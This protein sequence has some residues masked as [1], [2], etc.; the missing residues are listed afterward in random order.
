M[1]K[2]NKDKVVAAAAKAAAKTAAKQEKKKKEKKTKVVTKEKIRKEVD[3][4]VS[5]KVKK[6][7]GPK[8]AYRVR[9][10]ATLGHISGNNEHGPELK[11]S[12]FLHPSL[13]KGPDDGTEFG[14]L[15]AAAAQYGLWRCSS[16]RVVM[17]P[18]VGPSAVSGTVERLS[19]NLTQTPSS[20]NWGGLGA[21]KHMDAQAGTRHSIRFGRR[22]LAGPRDGGWWMTDTNAEGAQSA[23][24]LIEIHGLGQT[25]SAYQ[26]TPWKNEL[27][28]VELDGVWEFA[29]YTANPS[30]GQLDRK[31]EKADATI[32]TNTAGE[33]EMTLANSPALLRFMDDQTAERATATQPA[34]PGE[35]IFQIVD[36]AASLASQFAP[37]PFG[38]LIKGGWWFLKKI[39]GAAGDNSGEARFLV[40]PSLADAQNNRP[41][42][43]TQHSLAKTSAVTGTFQVTQINAPN[44]GG[45]TANTAATFRQTLPLNPEFPPAS[46]SILTRITAL[47]VFRVLQGAQTPM[48]S[49]PPVF[50]S[51]ALKAHNNTY[52]A[53]HFQAK[54][55]LAAFINSDDQLESFGRLRPHA[56]N[57]TKIASNVI[58]VNY[59]IDVLP[60]ATYSHTVSDGTNPAI[61]LNACI[62]QA[63]DS[64]KDVVW[65]PATSVTC[66]YLES[67][68]EGQA[69]NVWKYKPNQRSFDLQVNVG[70]STKLSDGP[71]LSIWFS[72]GPTGQDITWQSANWTPNNNLSELLGVLF[73]GGNITQFNLFAK[74]AVPRTKLSKLEKLASALG[75]NIDDIVSDSDTDQEPETASEGDVSESDDDDD[76]QS[77]ASFDV[78]PPQT[79]TDK[80]LQLKEQGLTHDQ[81]LEVLRLEEPAV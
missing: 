52:R 77:E 37:P 14:P 27:Y 72:K 2:S 51:S 53:A 43:S 16:A 19:L 62:W 73:L 38:W 79:K 22:D 35:V 76:T 30:L 61:Y 45:A 57:G 10:S 70:A 48:W 40:Y 50:V 55:V 42:V 4:E 71:W 41:A 66:G 26:N 21:R 54:D 28:I 8:P 49:F 36:T 56:K 81:I 20:T 6:L 11:M 47:K 17:T 33:I 69:G 64:D 3:K 7:E 12:T 25:M 34:K 68:P 1:P 44:M 18:L 63:Q 80:Y 13:V 15:Q 39:V 78:I 74:M 31:E 5:K 24:P 75:V 58:N 67:G 65:A 32:S 59:D 29:N 60:L 23:G 9:V 46:G